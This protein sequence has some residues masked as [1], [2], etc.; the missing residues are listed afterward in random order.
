MNSV[1]STLSQWAST[2]DVGLLDTRECTNVVRLARAAPAHT[3]RANITAKEILGGSRMYEL[4]AK[5]VKLAVLAEESEIENVVAFLTGRG[6]T[7]SFRF[8]DNDTFWQAARDHSD[9]GVATGSPLAQWE[10]RCVSPLFAPCSFLAESVGVIESELVKRRRDCE[11]DWRCL[12][13]GC[14]SGRDMIWLASRRLHNTEQETSIDSKTSGDG[15]KIDSSQS[16]ELTSVKDNSTSM[17]RKLIEH[18][19]EVADS[20]L[21]ASST[22]SRQYQSSTYNQVSSTKSH[23][24]RWKVIGVDSNAAALERVRTFARRYSVD[25]HIC[26]IRARLRGDG[27]V[28]MF[29][30]IAARDDSSIGCGHDGR[31]RFSES[32][33][34]LVVCIRFLERTF[35]PRLKEMV[36]PGGFILCY[37]FASGVEKFEH[38]KRPRFIVGENEFSDSFCSPKFKIFVNR[39]ETLPDGR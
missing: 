28:T 3:R 19:T 1:R 30:H 5:S 23:F 21:C 16:S 29:E 7:V 11:G 36:A 4:P 38:P 27:Q 34:D 20:P 31:F 18:S 39:R 2:S 9:I 13:L 12:D 22:S 15:E 37:Q 17:K 33:F 6:W 24:A 8:L 26:T 10:R 14:G 32:Q 25:N 35:F